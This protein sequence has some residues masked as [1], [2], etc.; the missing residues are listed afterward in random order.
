MKIAHRG[1]YLD[2]GTGSTE[3]PSLV[4]DPIPE[5]IYKKMERRWAVKFAQG[6]VLDDRWAPSHC[7]VHFGCRAWCCSARP[8]FLDSLGRRLAAEHQA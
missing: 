5:F 1:H 4:S 7:S 6:S 2:A 8:S 3:H